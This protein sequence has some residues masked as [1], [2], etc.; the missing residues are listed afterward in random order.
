MNQILNTIKKSMYVAVFLFVLSFVCINSHDSANAATK[1]FS[2]LKQLYPNG[3]VFTKSY[4]N[5]A[6]QCHS[7]A[8]TV[9]D[10]YAGSDPYTWNKVYNL[11]SLKPGDII[12]C[13]RPH[14]II[15]TAV[16]GDTVTYADCNWVGK[17]KV[18]W[19]QTI[20]RS[21]IT[22]KFGSLSYVMS[23]P[24]VNN[25]T[26]SITNVGI[27]SIDFFHI[28][29][30]FTANNAGMAR[31][32]IQSRNTGKSITS[33]YTSGL[34]FVSHAFNISDFPG[35]TELNVLIYAYSTTNGG[36]ETL[37]R[38]F[39]G[40]IPGFVQLPAGNPEIASLCFDYVYYA[41][42]NPDLKA[43]YGYNEQKLYNHWINFGIAEGRASS[44]AWDGKSGYCKSI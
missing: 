1:S 5:K 24:K 29:F 18:K 21:R 28:N 19:D 8:C 12:R 44:P 37:H 38:V 43:I 17:N 22:G 36:N 7:F 34:S 11:N 9:G 41:D 33:D 30:H 4:K 14:S 15:V 31:I 27:D 6:W 26:P 32:V 20:S 25:E 13:N 42:N 23:A 3:S 2:E 16:S 10:A 35:T 40:N 39:Y